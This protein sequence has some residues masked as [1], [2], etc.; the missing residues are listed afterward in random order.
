MQTIYFLYKLI[1]EWKVYTFPG[2]S[3]RYIY[4]W[5]IDHLCTLFYEILISLDK[6]CYLTEYLEPF[7]FLKHPTI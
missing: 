2:T 4:I 3:Y 6:T 5:S 7:I 1:K